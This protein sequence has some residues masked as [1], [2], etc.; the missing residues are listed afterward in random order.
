MRISRIKVNNFK[1]LVDFDLPMEKFTCLIGLNGCGKS[2]VLQFLDFLG[3]MMWG[4]FDEWYKARGWQRPDVVSHFVNSNDVRFEV[5]LER[6]QADSVGKWTG[7]F[8]TGQSRCVYEDV[9]VDGERVTVT[10]GQYQVSGMAQSVP[11]HFKYSGSL[12]SQLVAGHIPPAIAEFREFVSSF[13]SLE[14]MSVE[15]LRQPSTALAGGTLGHGGRDL[16]AYL[17]EMS[18]GDRNRLAADLRQIYPWVGDIGT[19]DPPMFAEDRRKHFVYFDNYP[20]PRDRPLKYAVAPSQMSDGVVRLT[21]LLAEI[22]TNHDFVLLDEIE[23]GINPEIVEFLVDKLVNARQQVMVTTHSPMILNYL[24]DEQAKKSVIY[25]YKTA[26]GHTKA[27]P[28]FDIPSMAEKLKVM[29]PGEVFVDTKLSALADE[30]A[31]LPKAG[32]P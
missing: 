18:V 21:A 32:A 25:L 8:D 15:G 30:I 28:F 14:T 4:G 7:T 19:L 20:A 10:G 11:I 3:Q 16:A 24:D 23:N 31:A 6:G 5:D 22:S 1:S 2:T 12:L 26:E 13:H 9:R 27:I 29:G 17:V